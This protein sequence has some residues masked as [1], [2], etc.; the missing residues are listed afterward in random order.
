M[1]KS[2]IRFILNPFSGPRKNI[3]IV[4]L[5][6]AQIDHKKID[7]EIIYTTH[8]RHAIELSREA[9]SLNY[10]AVVAVGGDGTINE[11]ASVLKDTKIALGIIPFG[12][13]NGF[14]YHLGIRRNIIK[15]INI[16]NNLN[17]IC[18]DTAMMNDEFF[19]NVAGLGLDAKV[20]FV[21]KKN[22][23][24]GF[25]PY[26]IQTLKEIKGFKFMKMDL[27]IPSLEWSGEYAMV[28]IANGSMYGYDFSIAPKAQ[29]NDSL[30]DV[31]LIKKV[32]VFR[33]FG[34]A[35]RMIFR[36]L[37]KSSIVEYLNCSELQ[38]RTSD[39]EFYHVDGEGH[40]S[41]TFEYNFKIFPSSLYLLT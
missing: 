21:T 22:Q 15:S 37:D 40:I 24:R 18:I 19:I 32:P 28:A 33:Y 10:F 35:I 9:V 2:K 11:V 8:P 25:L 39:A 30:F 4:S 14:S 7:P 5:I 13:G 1:L 41:N 6:E 31:V 38:I 17:K 3:D 16:I 26:F 20:A 23:T 29:M 34:L 12:S 27:K 36:T